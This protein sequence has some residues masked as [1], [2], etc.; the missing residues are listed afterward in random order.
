MRSRP[1]TR[2]VGGI[3][4]V[5][6]LLSGA[7]LSGGLAPLG[8]RAEVT[9]S[10]VEQAAEYGAPPFGLTVLRGTFD[11]AEL[12]A[13]WAGGGHQRIDLGAGEAY[14]VRE[15]FEIDL[16]DAGSRMALG[17]L[18]VVAI[19]NDGTLIFG[20]T[21]DGVRG[22]RHRALLRRA[23]RALP[24]RSVRALS[25]EPAVLIE[26]MPAAGLRPFILQDMLF[27]RIPGFPAR[28]W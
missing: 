2:Q 17:Y 18:N 1:V 16:S 27:R 6:L 9:A 12:Q 24:E 11:P 5:I 4:L 8:A 7:G 13:A 21:R 3:L 23:G 28:D 26:L 14:A 20:S 15:D 19:A 22:G 25:A 10:P